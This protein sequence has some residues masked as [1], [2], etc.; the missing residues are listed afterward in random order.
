MHL[1]PL[2]VAVYP[3][4]TM[5]NGRQAARSTRPSS[6]ASA[7]SVAP[8]STTSA[9]P[10]FTSIQKVIRTIFR[11]SKITVQQVE[12]LQGRLHQVFLARLVESSP[13]ILKCPPIY[14]NRLLRHEH[15]GLE[16]EYQVLELLRNHTQLSVPQVITYDRHGSSLG[17]PFLMTTHISGRRLSEMAPYLSERERLNIDETLGRY[18]RG[19]TSLPATQYGLSNRVFAGKGYALWRE[20]FLSLL[21]SVLRDAEDMLL[22]IDYDRIR[23]CAGRHNHFLNEVTHPQLVALDA[24]DPRKVLI[25]ERTKQVT[26]I[27]GFSNVIWGD[28]LMSG[29]LSNASPA[30]MKGY[31][32]I[33]GRSGGIRARQ[34]M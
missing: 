21:E 1:P 14:N 3:I 34:L 8:S 6:S 12:R 16:T 30:F 11:S 32:T 31:G 20:A 19:L 24:C 13:L 9:S 29:G 23:N 28:P 26:G 18:V 33:S 5:S 27:V 10:D 15:H 17:A 2:D 4:V 25:D 22:T 7:S